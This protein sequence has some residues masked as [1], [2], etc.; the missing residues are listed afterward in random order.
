MV[1]ANYR[2]TKLTGQLHR[3]V[4]S[5][6]PLVVVGL[7]SIQPVYAQS[8]SLGGFD[9]SVCP[10]NAYAVFH[11]CALEAAKTADPPRTLGGRPDFSGNWLRR[12]WAF[13]DFEAHPK[14]P[15][16]KILWAV[17]VQALVSE[18]GKN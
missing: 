16:D 2:I 9:D 15:D 12:A 17:N 8:S 13:E 3:A 6:I 14:N 4:T 10:D 7:F 18:P 5:G 1:V 11:Q